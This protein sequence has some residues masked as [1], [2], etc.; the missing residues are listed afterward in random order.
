MLGGGTAH[1]TIV[2]SVAV[3]VCVRSS[4]SHCII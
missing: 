3:S 4:S 1:L 2:V